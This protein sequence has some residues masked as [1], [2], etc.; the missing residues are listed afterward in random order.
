MVEVT[1]EVVS[2]DFDAGIISTKIL[3]GDLKG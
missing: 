2:G 1:T 3:C